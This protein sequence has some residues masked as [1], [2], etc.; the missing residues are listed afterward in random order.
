MKPKEFKC[1]FQHLTHY[2]E[3]YFQTEEKF[4]KE[5]GYQDYDKHVK[6]HENIINEINSTNKNA[7][8]LIQ[9][10]KKLETLI[11]SW[12]QNHILTEDKAYF[13]WY[14]ENKALK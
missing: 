4:M 1:L 2:V 11:R 10:R 12:I 9:L 7:E 8:N 3:T 14:K 13:L 6:Q 5:I